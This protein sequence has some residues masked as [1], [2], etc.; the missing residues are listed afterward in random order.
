MKKFKKQE[1]GNREV[2]D[3]QLSESQ[4]LEIVLKGTCVSCELMSVLVKSGP[5]IIGIGAAVYGLA[6]INVLMKKIVELKG[7]DMSE[8]YDETTQFFESVADSEE[9]NAGSQRFDLIKVC[10]YDR[11]GKDGSSTHE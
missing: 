10:E 3:F 5:G 2:R 8:I 4:A 9:F 7:F 11:N 1:K 6:K